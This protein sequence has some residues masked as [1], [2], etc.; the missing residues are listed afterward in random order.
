MVNSADSRM[1]ILARLRR[2]S[3]DSAQHSR[4]NPSLSEELVQ[5][6]SAPVE[7]VLDSVASSPDGLTVREAERRLATAGPNLITRKRQQS[8]AQELMGRSINPLNVLLLVLALVSYL[9]GDQ[10][11]ALVI[12]V[13]VVLSISLGFIQEH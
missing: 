11:A 3:R 13:M 7:K 5:L 6:S 2:R 8:V 10:P 4:L 12:A 9:L 1:G